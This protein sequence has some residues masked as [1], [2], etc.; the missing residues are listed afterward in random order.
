VFNS[1]SFIFSRVSLALLAEKSYPPAV[2][3]DDR[4]GS[5][6]VIS[7]EVSGKQKLYPQGFS[8]YVAEA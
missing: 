6:S 2:F 8:K 7:H 1:G 5:P 4:N 3:S